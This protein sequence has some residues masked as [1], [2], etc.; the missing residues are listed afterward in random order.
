MWE[1][2]KKWWEA[3]IH[4]AAF[5]KKQ[6]S[7]TWGEAFQQVIESGFISAIILGFFVMI[8]A[9]VGLGKVLGK[10]PFLP[11]AGMSG[12][13]LGFAAWMVM[14]AALPIYL[15]V[16]WFFGTVPLYASARLFGGKADFE[17]HLTNLAWLIAPV[18]FIMAWITWIPVAGIILDALLWLYALYP[19]TVILRDTHKFGI[20]A[21]L[22]T[23]IFWIVV[24]IL[25]IAVGGAAIMGLIPG[26]HML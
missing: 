16:V 25:I 10:I 23:W 24:D 5:L 26:L 18:M 15:L 13:G 22:C 11:L 12:W 20:G 2:I 8:L 7:T 4:P 19:L 3:F 17:E 6:K 14:L 9:G 1:D 21:A